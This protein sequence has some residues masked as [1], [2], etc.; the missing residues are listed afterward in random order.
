MTVL[1]E[2]RDSA[3]RL[4]LA[5]LWIGMGAGPGPGRDLAVRMQ[6]LLGAVEE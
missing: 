3:D 2:D 4:A 6:R 5:K 1:I